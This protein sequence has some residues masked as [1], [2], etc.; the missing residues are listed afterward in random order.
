E[1][2][3][4][5][6]IDVVMKL[7]EH[8]LNELLP[9]IPGAEKIRNNIYKL[10]VTNIDRLISWVLTQKQDALILEPEEVKEKARQALTSL[11]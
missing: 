8:R 11:L 10:R 6:A 9:E 1:I 7:S 2:Y 5:P 4:H 3:K